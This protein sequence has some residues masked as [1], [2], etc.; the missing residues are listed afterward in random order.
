MRSRC[1]ICGDQ[2]SEVIPIILPRE[3]KKYLN[4]KKGDYLFFL[5]CEKDYQDAHNYNFKFEKMNE[6]SETCIRKSNLK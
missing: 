3:L 5:L 1:Y 6:Y 4:K 2:A